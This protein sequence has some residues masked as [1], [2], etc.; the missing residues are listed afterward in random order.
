MHATDTQR[1]P[2]W[3]LP[4]RLFHWTLVFLIVSAWVSY[5]FA[6]DIGDETLIWH[7]ANGLAILVLIVWRILWGLWGS[8]TSRFSGFVPTPSAIMHYAQSLCSG[9]AA[10]YLGHNPLGALMVLALIATVAAISGFGLFATDDNDLVGGP[11]Y[12]LVSEQQNARAARL[13]DQLF[14]YL[15]LPLVALHVTVNALYTLVKKE[16]LIQAM[17][18]GKKPAEPYADAQEAGITARPGLRAMVCLVAA[19]ALV[20]GGIVAAGGRLALY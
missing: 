1:V 17:I 20:L 3:D 19:A 13:H 4:T 14:N 18:T 2:V 5:E 9:R 15:L 6:E 8:S 11:L 7:R 12:R 10:R 16:P